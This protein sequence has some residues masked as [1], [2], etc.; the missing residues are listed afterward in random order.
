[1]KPN[2]LFM[3]TSAFLQQMLANRLPIPLIEVRANII[4]CFPSTLVFST[5]RMCWKSSFA[6]RDCK[7]NHLKCD[8]SKNRAKKIAF[9]NC[10]KIKRIF[11]RIFVYQ[12]QFGNAEIVPFFSPRR[13]KIATEAPALG[14]LIGDLGF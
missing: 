3:S 10:Q 14:R 5:R 11:W 2:L 13:M 9:W 12:N 1:M 4:F 6:T 7:Q 8:S